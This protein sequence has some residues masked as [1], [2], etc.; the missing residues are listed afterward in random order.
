MN[1]DVTGPLV[2]V[3]YGVPADYEE[4]AKRG[5]DV[6]GKIAIARYGGSWRGIKP[7][8]AAEH[9]AVGCIIFS[10]PSGD[11]Y[12][13][14][15]TYPKGG[16]RPAQGVQRGSVADMPFHP[17]DPLTPGVGAVAGAKRLEIAQ[18][19]TLTKIPVLPI[20]ARD[21]QPLLA[22]MSGPMAPEGWR[23]SLPLPYHLGPGPAKVHL[24]LV[25]DWQV[26]P[27][28]DVIAKLPGRELPDEW[29]MRGN[30]HDAWVNGATDPV[31]GLA[32]LLA[33]AKAVA[34]LVRDGW[35]PGRTVVYAAWDGEEPGLLGSTEWAEQHAE[36]LQKKLLVYMNSDSNSR[37]FLGV[38][39]SHAL[40]PL[41]N[42]V[43][44]EVPDPQVSRSVLDRARA[45]MSLE[46]EEEWVRDAAKSGRDLPIAPLGS[47]SDYTPF[48][49]HLGI[50]SLDLGFGG[51]EHYGQ[52][53]SIYD[54]WDHYRRFGDPG[55]VYGAALAKVGGRLTT[56]LAEADLLPFDLQRLADT[57]GRYAD[58]VQ[59]LTAKMRDETTE[60]NRRIS[61]GVYA[62][63]WDPKQTWVVPAAKEPVPY[64]NFAPLANAVERLKE[65]A[66]RHAKA[67]AARRA[68]GPMEPA[69]AAPYDQA[70]MAIEHSLTRS[71]GL[72]GR[73]WFVH[74]V[75]APGVYTGYGVKTLP[76][77]R[78]AIEQRKWQEAEQQIGVLAEVLRGAA[79]AVDKATAVLESK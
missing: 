37:G 35:R 72:P 76:A 29:V 63:A 25:F 46:D 47:G 2:Y 49:Q 73:P 28:Y 62:A 60:E 61:E 78:E 71:E 50:A 26:R 10:D 42:Q 54:S 52:Y 65:A 79:A 57:V 15:D 33:E 53:H 23:G 30:H 55:F 11:G 48:L 16:W 27:I 58:E 3:N 56:R 45:W 41:V 6:K 18:A 7:K 8:V 39:G 69:A 36:E 4:L 34:S 13:E 40:E 43:A 64:L 51:E 77:V 31:S 5:I 21:A 70:L 20:S 75:Y 68:Q 66:G 9:G 67:V 19:R 17:G 74:Q 44:A 1:G 12:Y 24:K 14:G 22:A 38:G 59:K 32:A